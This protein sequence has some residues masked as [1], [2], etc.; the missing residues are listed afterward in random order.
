MPNEKGIGRPSSYTEEI[1]DEICERLAGGES[2][3]SICRDTHTPAISTVLLWVVDGKHSHFSEQYV[4][5]REA[6]GY[7]YADSMID[8]AALVG[9]GE[10]G[11]AEARVIMD[12]YKWTAE[13]NASK[14]YG[15]R[16]AL[17]HTS[18]DGSMTPKESFDA[19]QLSTA[20]LKE[21]M[22]ARAKPDDK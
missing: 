11:A 8:M 13:R 20:A 18:P 10:L 4:K 15:Q 16:K 14:A 1:G 19:S 9:A 12:A 3:R 17:E 7:F 2:L 6:Q 5:A 21:L 22:A